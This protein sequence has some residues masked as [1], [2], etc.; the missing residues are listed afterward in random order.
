MLM[1]S[2]K[3][4]G[5]VHIKTEMIPFF[6]LKQDEITKPSYPNSLIPHNLHSF[7]KCIFADDLPS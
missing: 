5:Y 4:I 1:S 3:C 6:G 2:Q 7:T